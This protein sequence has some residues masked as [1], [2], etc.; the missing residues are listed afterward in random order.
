MA[1]QDPRV[2]ARIRLEKERRKTI[3]QVASW[4]LAETVIRSPL[5]QVVAG[6][7]ATETAQKYGLISGAWAGG[8]EGAIIAFVGAQ[9]YK[10]YGAM[11]AGA[12]GIGGLLGGIGG[13]FTDDFNQSWGEA[14]QGGVLDKDTYSLSY[15][16]KLFTPD[17]WGS[18]PNL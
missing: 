8:I 1:K 2:K 9:A 11:G 7:I 13:T 16:K 5:F 6:V 10:D 15:L 17:I 14:I 12:L 18:D 3:N 4:R